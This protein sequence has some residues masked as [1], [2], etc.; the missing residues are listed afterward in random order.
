MS[1]ARPV[2]VG[3]V[4]VRRLRQG[5]GAHFAR[6]L[7]RAGAAVPA[8]IARSAASA[9]EGRA[10]L[11]E[12]R[13]DAQG[14]TDLGELLAAHPLDALVVASPAD[15]HAEWLER[16]LAARLHV[17]CEKPLVADVGDPV[18]AAAGFERRFA[19]AGRVL[20][21]HCQWPEV[22]PTFAELH[23]G[24]RLGAVREFGMELAPAS[25][26]AAMLLDAM[27]HPLS[28]LQALRPAPRGPFRTE[29]LRFSTTDPAAEDLTVG[30]RLTAEGADPI[31]ATVRLRRVD[32]QPRPAALVLDGHRAD[33]RIR[34]PG[35]ALSLAGEGRELPLPDPM[36]RRVARF[37]ARVQAS[38]AGAGDGIAERM[39]LLTEV[40]AAFRSEARD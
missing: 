40:V 27:S 9:A 22:L 10:L 3:I 19:A 32:A 2:Q 4:G 25:A 6:W 11:A 39:R 37:V 28:V 13:I 16:A 12:D 5:L 17:L 29:A 34:L 8:F 31:D 30:F 20:M 21:E 35:Y 7:V 18:V 1:G 36:G 26:G 38:D 14:F 33:R 23:P 24:V 15:T